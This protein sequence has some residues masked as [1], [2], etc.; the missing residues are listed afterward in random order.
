MNKN[1][2]FSTILIFFISS[3]AFSIH[4]PNFNEEEVVSKKVKLL[5]CARDIIDDDKTDLDKL[6]GA[7]DF[8]DTALNRTLSLELVKYKLELCKKTKLNNKRI[9]LVFNTIKRIKN[10]NFQNKKND[11]QLVLAPP[12]ALRNLSENFISNEL[13]NLNFNPDAK[14]LFLRFYEPKSFCTEV[15]WELSAAV[16][17]GGAIGAGVIECF[18][19]NGRGWIETNI[20]ISALAGFALF[21][22]GTKE[23]EVERPLSG[24]APKHY[25]DDNQ[26]VSYN[27]DENPS[28]INFYFNQN[29]TYNDLPDYYPKKNY[30][31]PGRTI[32]RDGDGINFR[33]RAFATY[34]ANFITGGELQF[35]AEVEA[36][37]D[38]DNSFIGGSS[39]VE[40]LYGAGLGIYGSLGVGLGGRVLDLGTNRDWFVKLVE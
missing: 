29:P 15:S 10:L 38:R 3:E 28:I 7:L 35:V 18:A 32:V 34:G 1:L 14:E 16:G 40:D 4:W 13:N 23:S 21:V 2:L 37:I 19:S 6:I 11:Q 20:S 17:R 26:L 30:M 24:Q 33:A 22:M 39:I 27:E 9:N 36:N 31:I 12:L 5:Y 25:I 8:I